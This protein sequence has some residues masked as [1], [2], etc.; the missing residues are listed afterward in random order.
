MARFVLSRGQILS[1]TAEKQNEIWGIYKGAPIRGMAYLRRQGRATVETPEIPGHGI[2][3]GGAVIYVFCKFTNASG[4]V[5]PVKPAVFHRVGD[6]RRQLSVH[7]S[8]DKIGNTTERKI[9]TDSDGDGYRD[10]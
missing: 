2:F 1:Y 9:G 6:Y 8:A 3:S 7:I 5:L 4:Q 10:H